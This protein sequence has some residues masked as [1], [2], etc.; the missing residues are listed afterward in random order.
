MRN[1]H[2]GAR[3]IRPS[4]HAKQTL[5]H[6][7]AKQESAP[8]RCM[9]RLDKGTCA[10]DSNTPTCR[11]PQAREKRAERDDPT[12]DTDTRAHTPHPACKPNT[13]NRHGGAHKPDAK[14]KTTARTA[15]EHG[16]TGQDPRVLRGADNAKTEGRKN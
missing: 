14:S 16:Y 9:E 8:I 1:R 3:S 12:R 13:C 10:W 5:F 2:G 11:E 4:H 7:P 15:Q 6:Q